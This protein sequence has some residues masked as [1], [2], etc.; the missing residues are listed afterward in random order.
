[1]P[2]VWTLQDGSVRVM[3][4]T[5]KF[6]S[7]NTQEGETTADAVARLA[8][9]EREKNPE[10]AGATAT[11]VR[12]ADMPADRTDRSKWRLSNGSVAVDPQVPDPETPDIW[13]FIEGI[14]DLYAD[15]AL[16][17]NAFLVKYP[18][19]LWSMQRM[20]WP[21]VRQLFQVAVQAND[22]APEK[23]AQIQA[24]AST[25]YIPLVEKV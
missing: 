23:W 11:L 22:I 19:F 21:A 8:E 3:R 2:I 5:D 18:M 17:L 25:Y 14:K 1:M 7:E 13:G 24:L 20:N 16:V 4:L 9:V 6:L 15:D 10:L 12:S